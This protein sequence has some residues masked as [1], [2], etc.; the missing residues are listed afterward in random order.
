MLGDDDP[1]NES[2]GDENARKDKRYRYA[3]EDRPATALFGAS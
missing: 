1:C 2:S 3:D